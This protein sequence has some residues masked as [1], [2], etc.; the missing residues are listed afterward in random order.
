MCDIIINNSSNMKSIEITP[1]QAKSYI[2]RQ[3]PNGFEL[4]RNY[5]FGKVDSHLEACAVYVA[6][7]GL[8]VDLQ[9]L[10]GGLY[11]RSPGTQGIRL[12]YD[13][14]HNR[15]FGHR[16]VDYAIEGAQDRNASELETDPLEAIQ[17][18]LANRWRLDDR[19]VSIFAVD[20]RG[21]AV[22]VSHMGGYVLP[23]DGRA[24]DNTV[25][26]IQDGI[27]RVFDS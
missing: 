6:L 20:S 7:T 12:K 4:P 2:S 8:T 23:E 22:L 17:F 13:R 24:W 27:K 14:K 3:H 15:D 1:E 18:Q 19:P 9:L 25:R 16:Q 26:G 11:S 5:D 21:T 10:Y